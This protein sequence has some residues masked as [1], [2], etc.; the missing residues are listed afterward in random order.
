MEG[1]N[2]RKQGGQPGNQNARRHGYYC[3]TLDATGKSDYEEARTVGGMED[4]IAL[5]RARIRGVLRHD[6]NNTRLLM[7]AM[8]SLARMLLTHRQL[9]KDDE[10]GLDKA[11]CGV[12][13]I[14]TLPPGVKVVKHLDK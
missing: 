10:E 6:P 13:N 11:M 2:N 1:F 4:E 8:A 9:A 14:A 5:M 12:L 7:L 3:K